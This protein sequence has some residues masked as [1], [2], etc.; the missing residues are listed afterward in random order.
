MK[1]TP[2][3]APTGP[4]TVPEPVAFRAQGRCAGHVPSSTAVPL[5]QPPQ[6]QHPVILLAQSR[7]VQEDVELTLISKRAQRSP[8]ADNFRPSN[9]PTLRSVRFDTVL[10]Q[11]GGRQASPEIPRQ[12]AFP[13]APKCA[14]MIDSSWWV[15]F[16]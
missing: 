5:Y 16:G 4:V 10:V 12:S 9:P 7:V 15:G 6:F 1:S 2:G 3:L 13:L 14:I 11:P 8:S